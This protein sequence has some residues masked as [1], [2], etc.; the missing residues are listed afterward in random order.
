[1][2]EQT[3]LAAT[4]MWVRTRTG[5]YGYVGTNN[6]ADRVLAGTDMFP[7]MIVSQ[8][9]DFDCSVRFVSRVKKILVLLSLLHVLI[10]TFLCK[11]N[12]T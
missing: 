9:L 6:T 1:M 7:K 4:G 8:K 3:L 12:Y 2:W 5:G 10:T 11:I